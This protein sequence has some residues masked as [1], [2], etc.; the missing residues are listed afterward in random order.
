MSV[1]PFE[2][3]VDIVDTSPKISDEVKLTTCYMCACRCGIKVHLKDDK[4]R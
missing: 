1:N 4:V 3:V 2:T